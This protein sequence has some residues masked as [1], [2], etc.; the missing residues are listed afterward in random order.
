MNNAINTTVDVGEERVV[1]ML[2]F[3]PL[4]GGKMGYVLHF[5]GFTCWPKRMINSLIY[6][7]VW[8][9]PAIFRELITAWLPTYELWHL[10]ANWLILQPSF[11]PPLLLLRIFPPLL[12]YAPSFVLLISCVLSLLLPAQPLLAWACSFPTRLRTVARLPRTPSLIKHDCPYTPSLIKHNCPYTPSLFQHDYPYNLSLIQHDC[13]TYLLIMFYLIP[14]V[15]FKRWLT[16]SRDKRLDL[17][18]PIQSPSFLLVIAEFFPARVSGKIMM[19]TSSN[20]VETWECQKCKEVAV[21]KTSYI[22]TLVLSSLFFSSSRP[23]VFKT[24]MP[25]DIT[26]V[27]GAVGSWVG[28]L[29]AIIFEMCVLQPLTVRLAGHRRSSCPTSPPLT[30]TL[31]DGNVAQLLEENNRLL[32]EIISVSRETNALLRRQARD[33]RRLMR[34]I[35]LGSREANDLR[36]EQ[37]TLLRRNNTSTRVHLLQIQQIMLT[38]QANADLE[39]MQTRDQGARN[40]TS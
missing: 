19:M 22:Y 11:A 12:S 27:F 15:T 34:H 14:F 33:N 18:K 5:C 16:R 38:Q 36:R 9:S 8:R 39:M 17:K 26:S 25:L 28:G 29:L 10:S 24:G 35:V 23:S 31:P 20:W 13:P 4:S 40:S 32:R 6:I 3:S 2:L 7:E 37:V 1:I 30:S 21:R